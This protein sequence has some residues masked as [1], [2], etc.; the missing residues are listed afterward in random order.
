MSSD[1]HLNCSFCFKIALEVKK[2]IAG[3]KVYICD[4]CV[5][6]CYGILTTE[7]VKKDKTA[8]PSPKSIKAHLD[9]YVIGQDAAK[10]A[11]AVAVYNHYKRLNNPVV[12]DVELDKSNILLLGPTGSGKTLLA[13][14]IAR[15]L[16]VPF[17]IAD[18]TSLTEAGYVGED[19]ESVIT[20]L[21]QSC[22]QDV[23]KAQRGIVYIDEIDKKRAKGETGSGTRDV[24][25]EGVQQALLKIIE[26]TEVYV[27]PTGRKSNGGSS[28]KVKVDTKNILF[29]VGGAF[30]GL[31]KVIQ[32][33]LDKDSS[34]MGFSSSKVGKPE[35]LLSELHARIEPKHLIQFGLIPEMVG[36]L[37]IVVALDEL[38]EEQ[39][40][41]IMTAPRNAVVKQFTKMFKL[42]SV[43]LEFETEALSSVARIAK[44]RKTG[45]RGLRSVLE[46]RLNK[47]QFD[48]PELR[49]R[50][51]VKVIVTADVINNFEE[52]ILV[53]GEA[54]PETGGVAE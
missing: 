15:F 40:I 51:I 48:L 52:P 3:P 5:N 24:S 27:S 16:D 14:S 54:A 30:V 39:L 25:G 18:A 28:E 43:E 11:I 49:E 22:G 31:E 21:L 50:G 42:D 2:L 6:L 1:E 17:A 38:D 7:E 12:D 10:S 46:S 45:A 33:E 32:K 35:R 47:T 29:I 36:R 34:S 44:E 8:L 9:Q 20:R 19:V 37:P 26:G 53:M 41:N 4:E 13:Q 23:E